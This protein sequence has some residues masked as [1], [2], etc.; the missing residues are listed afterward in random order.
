[1]VH[2]ISNTTGTAC[3]LNAALLIIC[4]C[5]VPIRKAVVQY[6]Q[7]TAAT[8]WFQHFG[9][10]LSSLSDADNDDGS[11][12]DPTKFYQ[13]LKTEIGIEAHELGDAVTALVKLLQNVR[14][15]VPAMQPLMQATIDA[16][17]VHS[18][19]TGLHQEAEKKDVLKR[20]KETKIRPMACPFSLSG[21]VDS[22]ETAL[23]AAQLPQ[24]LQGYTWTGTYIEHRLPPNSSS[25]DTYA[26]GEWRNS[27]NLCIDAIPNMWL[28]HLQRFDSTSQG[29]R[30][31]LHNQAH[32]PAILQVAEMLHNTE[33]DGTYELMGGVAHV[34][35]HAELD[36]EDGHYVAIV[37]RD[38]AWFLVDDAKVSELSQETALQLL[39]GSNHTGISKGSYM[40][41]VLLVYSRDDTANSIDTILS[42]FVAEFA[43]SYIDWK[44]PGDL[45]GRRLR[46]KWTKGKF[47]PGLIAGYNQETGKHQVRYNDGDVREYRLQQKTIEWQQDTTP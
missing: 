22:V 25:S 15:G 40:Q 8:A 2:G 27:K 12:V 21:K 7:T 30:S 19:I 4:H 41:G 32:V 44:R 6:S 26:D 18:V 1:M 38:D 45:V 34:S 24:S 28:L 9:A 31:S 33:C 39:S 5:L 42:D 14:Q 36:E 23:Q 46:V 3:H 37:R 47:Y 29:Q 11:A 10:F 20:S 17:R 43:G 35:D 16:G 13:A